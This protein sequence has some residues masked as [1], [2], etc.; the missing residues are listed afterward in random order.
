MMADRPTPTNSR[1][2]STDSDAQRLRLAGRT[3]AV[4]AAGLMIALVGVGCSGHGKHTQGHKN[5]AEARLAQMKSATEW[6]MARQAYLAGDLDKALKHVDRSIA[7]NDAVPKSHV[8]R[9]RIL[10]EMGNFEAAIAALETAAELDPSNVDAA[11]YSGLCFER[12]A[13]REQALEFYR[14]AAT[15]DPQNG[16]YAVAAAE[17]LIDLGELDEARA[18]LED[19]AETLTHNPG[20][21]QA[22]GQIAL[23][24]QRPDDAHEL[25]T[26]ARLLAPDDAA[27][28]EDLIRAQI[29]TERFAEAE[30]HIAR[31]VENPANAARRDLQHMRARCLLQVDRPLEAREILISLTSDQSGTKDVEAWIMLGHTSYVLGD[32]GRLKQ[33]AARVIALAPTRSEG[34]MLR[35]MW[36]RQSGDRKAA[37]DT[38]DEAVNFRG[39]DTAPL[40]LRAI[41][42]QELGRLDIAEQ[43]LALASSESPGD[44]NISRLLSAIR[45]QTFAGASE[46][47]QP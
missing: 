6:D 17:M 46:G 22:L 8:L 35:A 21:K 26:E 37:L 13:K 15:L 9:G 41:V 20:V 11:Y 43:S 18:Y 23:L 36:Q 32:I 42:A 40:V 47:G 4:S 3:L 44:A 19:Q 2:G 29:A 33:S 24:Q 16:Q 45:Q 5:A 31:L 1:H 28:L 25:L 30:Y 39:T 34:Y 12:I 10:L 38:L 7:L 27:I 14:L